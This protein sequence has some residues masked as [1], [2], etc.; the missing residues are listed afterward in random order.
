MISPPR[1]GTTA[2]EGDEVAPLDALRATDA[3]PASSPGIADTA[4]SRAPDLHHSHPR[5]RAGRRRDARPGFA[6]K[7]I[8][9]SAVVFS[10]CKDHIAQQ[11]ICT[12]YLEHTISISGLFVTQSGILDHV[13]R[14]RETGSLSFAFGHFG[15][16]QGQP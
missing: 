10:R 8:A 15:G 3:D 9:E 13:T 6:T 4:S 2:N 16:C 1:I 12:T 7:L 11:F 14:T 5:P